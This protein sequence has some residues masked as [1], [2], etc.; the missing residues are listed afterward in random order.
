MNFVCKSC[1]QQHDLSEISFGAEAPVQWNLI[2]DEDQAN[3]ELGGEQCVIE[4]RGKRYLF[5]RACL[6][7]PIAGTDR[8]FTWGVWVSLSES[9]FLEMSEHWENP[10]RTSLGPYFGWLCTK[11]PEY[12]DTVFLK[13]MVH[14]RAV[15]QRPRVELEQTEHQL[16]IDQHQGIEPA[17]MQEIISKILHT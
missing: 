15:G 16:S 9:S 10:S 14:Q 2:S 12:P 1:G 17:R 5:V 7:L 6:D 11:I 13:T 4:T 8:V 3:S